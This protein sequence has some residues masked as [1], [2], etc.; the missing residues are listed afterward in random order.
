[1]IQCLS[2]GRFE[3]KNAIPVLLSDAN[4]F[5]AHFQLFLEFFI[6]IGILNLVLK[7]IIFSIFFTH[8]YC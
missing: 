8:P 1:M 2:E 4:S 3:S 6:D 7:L 5:L